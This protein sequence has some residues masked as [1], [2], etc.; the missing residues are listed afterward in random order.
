MCAADTLIIIFL[1][2]SSGCSVNRL[3][4]GDPAGDPGRIMKYVKS[5]SYEEDLSQ[6]AIERVMR[7]PGH[8]VIRDFCARRLEDLGFKVEL[9]SYG[10]GVNVIGRLEG[11]DNPGEEVLISAHYDSKYKGCPG[12]DDN[13]S[14]VAGALEAAT[15]LSKARYHRTL[16]VALWDE[17]EKGI[18]SPRGLIGSRS[19][20]A[21][22][23]KRGERIVLAMVFE[24]IGYCSSEPGSQSVPRIWKKYFPAE[25]GRI[26]ANNY[27]G[28]FTSVTVKNDA[29]IYSDLFAG[30]A[31]SL[32]L[33][34]VSF[35][36]STAVAYNHEFRR[37]DHA[38][39][40]ENGYPAML[41]SDTTSY[42]NRN[43]HCHYGR[44][45]DMSKIDINF[46]CNTVKAAVA[47]AASVL[48][49]DN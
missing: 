4:M 39:F 12:A 28:D 10:T 40:W 48:G 15:V 43:Y 44:V 36:L 33:P 11:T 8:D 38:A 30:F 1:L 32:S 31:E 22:A 47:T 21:R 18:K 17:E 46:A 35:K 41:I 45:D 42:R 5:S 34:A 3:V 37:S 2:I 16:V 6:I 19:F 14:G 27:R 25:T 9:D 24:M 13:A 49:Y 29:G 26:A 7:S 20:A 23:K